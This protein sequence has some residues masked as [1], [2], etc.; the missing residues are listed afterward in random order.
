MKGIQTSGLAWGGQTPGGRF[1]TSQ[2][3]D[4]SA[5]TAGGDLSSAR[6]SCGRAGGSTSGLTAGGDTAAGVTASVEEYAY[7]VG[8]ATVSVS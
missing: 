7:P 2:S 8:T 6:H 4:G 1:E 5:W 3:Y